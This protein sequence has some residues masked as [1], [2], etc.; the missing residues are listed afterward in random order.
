LVYIA[1]FMRPYALWLPIGTLAAL[2]PIAVERRMILGRDRLVILAPIASAIL[3]TLY[4]ARVGGDFMHAR[5]MLPPMLLAV[6][7]VF[8]LPIRR[9][10]ISIEEKQ[11]DPDPQAAL[12][13]CNTTAAHYVKMVR[14]AKEYIA[15]GDIFQVVLSQRFTA[16]FALP[17]FS[18][19][20]ALRRTN[21]S[22]FL[23]HLDFGTYA[24]VGSSYDVNGSW[25][26]LDTAVSDQF[27]YWTSPVARLYVPTP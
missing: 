1:D 12:P 5:M 19:Y 27:R 23:F 17:S 20:R 22:P 21:P 16:P 3:M 9:F 15:A 8:V 7:P 13:A 25:W 10:T 6:L 26:A 11:R 14:Q 4:I 2:A 24:L 18:L